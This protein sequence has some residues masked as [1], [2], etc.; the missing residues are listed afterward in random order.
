MRIL[1]RTVTFAVTSIVTAVYPT[2]QRP[3]DHDSWFPDIAVRLRSLSRRATDASKAVVAT[4]ARTESPVLRFLFRKVVGRDANIEFSRVVGLDENLPTPPQAPGGVG[5]FQLVLAWGQV[6]QSKTTVG[7]G[8]LKMRIVKDEH[9]SAHGAMEDA[10]DAIRTADAGGVL[11]SFDVLAPGRH[12]HIERAAQMKCLDIMRGLVAV[13]KFDSITG[14]NGD[15]FGIEPKI[16]LVDHD[17]R[18]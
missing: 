2:R 8:H 5:H 9:P 12:I 6:L 17:G 16:L 11:E 18:G 14:P 3:A 10:A 15:R 7:L 1:S 13:E 4:C